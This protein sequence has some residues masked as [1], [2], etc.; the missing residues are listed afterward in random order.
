MKTRTKVFE[1]KTTI[2]FP[3]CDPFNHLNNGRYIDYFMNA[4]EDHLMNAMGFNLYQVAKEKGIAWVVRRNQISYLRPVLLMETVVIQS[5][6]TNWDERGLRIE[7][8]M[9]N[10][11]KTVLKALL[12]SDFSHFNLLT[13][14][15]I[16]HS[17]DIH[18]FFAPYENQLPPEHETFEERVNF[19]KNKT[20]VE[21]DH[22]FSI[23]RRPEQQRL[24]IAV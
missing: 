8:R 11:D 9:W 24:A 15:G 17:E 6:I 20:A 19:L 7:M 4:R 18:E 22:P 5:T 2:R 13:S 14:K 21:L 3:D 16:R 10:T 23:Y 12:W 1:S